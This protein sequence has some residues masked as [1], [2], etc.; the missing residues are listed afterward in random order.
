M[1]LTQ[2]I[3]ETI[4]IGTTYPEYVVGSLMPLLPLAVGIYRLKYTSKS[5]KFLLFFIIFFILSDVPMWITAALKINNLLYGH[6]R[7]F[8]ICIFL[9]LTYFIGRKKK[10]DKK[11]L[12]SFLS[13]MIIVMFLEFF[14][15]I[16]NGQHKWLIGL[17][18]GSVSVWYFVRLLD[19]PKIK[20]I[21]SY[22]FFWF[23]SGILFYCFSTI[24]IFF[25]F[26]FTIKVDVYKPT[27]FLFHKF[28][29]YLTSVMFVLFAIGFWNLKKNAQ[30]KNK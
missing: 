22:P 4:R 10:N 20:D 8:L 30:I 23:N 28:L 19:Y 21:L 6:T 12:L 9:L 24:L 16:E 29:E 2:I 11:I 17:L 7:H 25:F 5:S 26:K 14:G 27:H 15:I 13:I 18:L 3:N 1:Q